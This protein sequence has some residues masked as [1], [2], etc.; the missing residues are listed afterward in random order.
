[1]LKKGI[2]LELVLVCIWSLVCVAFAAGPDYKITV[3][4]RLTD[5]SGNPIKQK[6][7]N[8]SPTSFQLDDGSSPINISPVQGQVKTDDFGVFNATFSLP[9]SA[10]FR[11][12]SS[13]C[14]LKINT[15]DNDNNPV[16]F[17]QA[18]TSAP[19]AVRAKQATDADNA[20]TAGTA[21]TANTAISLKGVTVSSYEATGQQST[22]LGTYTTASGKGSIALGYYSIASGQY[23][24]ALGSF[25]K[26]Q[27]IGSI[28]LGNNI[29]VNGTYSIG[30]GLD[31]TERT[32]SKNNV[33]TIMGGN[34]GIGTTE[35]SVLLEVKGTIAADAIAAGNN[36]PFKV[37]YAEQGDLYASQ[38]LIV[39]ALPSTITKDN[40]ISINSSKMSPNSSEDPQVVIIPANNW[41]YYANANKVH[42]PKSSSDTKIM[43][44]VVY[45]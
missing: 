10:P 19:Y 42:I 40:I 37:Y 8:P 3:Q 5:N 31:N 44:Q 34:V 23:S 26:A 27:G 7:I 9:Q 4:G 11:T 39:F 21:Q 41:K 2:L 33:V 20:R 12:L 28:A 18:L 1:M 24:T 38:T 13:Q 22:A 43:I 35:P 6:I 14:N 17:T 29:T 25:T 30:I 16:T 36:S 32:S 15:T 45:K